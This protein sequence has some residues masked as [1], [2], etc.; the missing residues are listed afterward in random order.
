MKSNSFFQ[1]GSLQNIYI[2]KSILNDDTEFIFKDTFRYLNRNSTLKNNRSYFKS[3]SLITPNIGN[4]SSILVYDCGLTL[5]FIRLNIHLNLKTESHISQYFT[6]CSQY[7]LKNIV[8]NENKLIQSSREFIF[9]NF[10]LY[11]MWLILLLILLTGCI[12]CSR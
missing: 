8:L 9:S 11:F 7:V 3:L 12:L 6:Q 2:S 10:F 1:L 4:A 5:H